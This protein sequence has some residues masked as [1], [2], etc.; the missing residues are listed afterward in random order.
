MK[1]IIPS[2]TVVS[3]ELQ[4]IGKLPAVIYPVDDKIVFD[5]L[6]KQYG[7]YVR[8]ITVVCYE[9][10]G[11]VME[12][13]HPYNKSSKIEFICLDQLKDLGYSIYQALEDKHEELIINFGDTI[14]QQ[15]VFGQSADLCFYEEDYLSE[16]WTFFEIE[17]GEFTEI[18][19]KQKE[20]NTQERKKMFVGVFK[21]SDEMNF[22]DC[23]KLAL[24][25][26]MDDMGSFYY[27]LQ[28]YSRKH[29]MK[30]VKVKDWFDIGHIDRYYNSKLEVKARE[31]NHITIDKNRGILTKT[32]NEKNKFIGEILW[33]LKLP[34][35]IEYVRPRIFSYDTSYDSPYI[36]MEYYAYHTVHELF[37]YGDLDW[38]QWS[39]LFRRIKFIYKD[40]QR[41]SL[42]DERM[43]GAL[44]EMYLHKT[45]ERLGEL[46]EDSSFVRLYRENFYINGNGFQ[47]IEQI[48]GKLKEEIPVYLYDVEYFHI[49]HGD[50]CFTNIMVD[51][52]L[53]FVKVVDPRGRFGSYDIYGDQRYE[54]AK[55]FHSIDGKYDYIIKDLFELKT[56]FK[57]KEI[58]INYKILDR[59][60]EFDLFQ[61]FQDTFSDEIGDEKKKIELIEALLFLSMIPLHKENVEHQYVMLATGIE[62][63][64][65]ILNIRKKDIRENE[66]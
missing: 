12:C 11:K 21:I 39:E 45:L 65:R 3:K 43:R 37:L 9:M 18:F 33:Y 53:S 55:L 4:S 16:K 50:L 59:H 23:L 19:D 27:A 13:L 32:S 14:V 26:K 10:A 2:A 24:Q 51:S 44:E 34:S 17:Q 49:I 20:A 60:R 66:G 1:L 25:T 46:K 47:S 35:D 61:L 15:D 57:Q 30:A 64:D 29:H 36:S 7:D 38:H 42:H 28:M 48:C 8:K 31:F 62:I 22:K 40:F 58:R 41:Y 5:Y 6:W 54:L 63:L 52:N 56:D